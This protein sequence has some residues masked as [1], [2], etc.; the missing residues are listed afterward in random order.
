MVDGS[1][2]SRNFDSEICTADS[3][4]IKTAPP[5]LEKSLV[6]LRKELRTISMQ[7]A[8]DS[9]KRSSAH[10]SCKGMHGRDADGRIKV[11]RKDITGIVFNSVQQNV[12]HSNSFGVD[13]GYGHS[14]I[15]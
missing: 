9:T 14:D 5:E 10:L 13:H 2:Q 4:L 11:R 3:E 6:R 1:Q 7:S 15:L 8:S 12:T